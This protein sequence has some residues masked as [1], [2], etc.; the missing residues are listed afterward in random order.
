MKLGAGLT[1]LLC[2]FGREAACQTFEG[3]DAYY[4][5]FPNRM[6]S[7]RGQELDPSTD[8]RADGRAVW[9]THSPDG[10]HRVEVRPG[11]SVFTIDGRSIR[12]SSIR[13]FEQEVATP[14]DLGS[15]ATAFFTPSLAC[16]EGTPPSASGTA[17]RHHSVFLVEYESKS[18][19]VWKLPTLFATCSALRWRGSHATFDKIT[20]RW[21]SA[22][23]EPEGL[24]LEEFE[25]ANSKFSPT[26]SKRTLSFVEPGNVYRFRL[27]S[28]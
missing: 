7:D 15:G 8:L 3:Y 5:T 27:N 20:Y 18:P 12:P 11:G 10:R 13:T 28:R 1:V 26:G 2:L 4:A 25:I 9:Q 19:R 6:F 16:I 17:T 22:N 23:D 24:D 14:F 21:S